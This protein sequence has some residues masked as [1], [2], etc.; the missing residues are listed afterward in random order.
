MEL[1]NP[2]GLLCLARNICI[3][4]DRWNGGQRV[5]IHAWGLSCPRTSAGGAEAPVS[6]LWGEKA[7]PALGIFP[8]WLSDVYFL[9]SKPQ[10]LTGRAQGL[11]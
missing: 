9:P 5:L 2:L 10:T 4:L 1:S 11:G 7:S 6:S 8:L 3:S